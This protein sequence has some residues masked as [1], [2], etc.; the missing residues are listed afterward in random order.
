[1]SGTRDKQGGC[2][3]SAVSVAAIIVSVILLQPSPSFCCCHRCSSLPS[4]SFHRHCL[5]LS[6]IFRFPVHV[7]IDR[8]TERKIGISAGIFGI[9]VFRNSGSQFGV[10]ENGTFFLEKSEKKSVNSFCLFIC[11]CY[12]VP[13]S[14]RNSCVPASSTPIPVILLVRG[15]FSQSCAIHYMELNKSSSTSCKEKASKYW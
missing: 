3:G 8:K 12:L 5:H 7:F 6:C 1:V 2:Y 11:T 9:P 13:Y 14:C 15:R 4:S 10:P